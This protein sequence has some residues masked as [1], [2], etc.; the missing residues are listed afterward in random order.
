MPTGPIK[1]F[2]RGFELNEKL[3]TMIPGGSHTY[4]KGEDQFPYLSPRVMERAVGAHCWDVDGNRYIDWAMGNRVLILGH[5]DPVVNEAVVQAIAGGCNYSRPGLI[6][7][8]TAEMLLELLP[9]FDMVKFGKNGSDVTTA[10][11]RL[12]RAATGRKCVAICS[13]HPFFSTHDWFIGTS[14]MNA[15][16]P[17]EVARLSLGFR[18]NDLKSLES[19]VD[20]YPNQIAAVILEPVKNDEP[21]NGFL[22]G[23]REF[24]TKHGIV[25]IFDEMI[26]GL[27]FDLRGA[28][29]RWGVYPDIAVFGKSI[30]NGFSFSL[31]AGRRDI[32]ELGGLRHAGHRVFLLSQ[33]HSSETTGLAACQATLKEYQRHDTNAHIWRTGKQLV[34]GFRALARSEHVLHHVRIIGFDCNPQIVCTHVDGTYWPELSAVFHEEVISQGVLIPWISIT[35]SHGSAELEQTLS[36]CRHG[37]QAVAR[38]LENGNVATAFVGEAPKPVFRPFNRCKQSRCGLLYA[39]APQLDC[40]ASS[41]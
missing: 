37:M 12:A 18:Y 36:A 16:V 34:E 33:T 35:Q 25:L 28:H 13:D 29:H 24:T 4:S 21:I 7:Y 9:R 39:D 5:A 3:H 32:M 8:Q 14:S 6:E 11:V 20:R 38:A 27:R 15:G 1:N 23:L 41:R 30:A 2:S 31:L 10:A 40:C 26:S 17:E 22:E 19:L